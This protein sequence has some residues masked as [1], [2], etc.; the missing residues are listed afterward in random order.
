MTNLQ[1][2]QRSYA[3]SRGWIKEKSEADLY[4]DAQL[5]QNQVHRQICAYLDGLYKGKN[6]EFKRQLFS[7]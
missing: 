5:K 1:M 3:L 6:N 4:L 2:L 7:C